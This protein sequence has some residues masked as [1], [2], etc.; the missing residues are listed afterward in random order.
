MMSLVDWRLLLLLLLLLLLH[1]V[2]GVVVVSLAAE[3]EVECRGWG[4]G[5][6]GGRRP[7]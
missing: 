6:W 3:E 4:Q 7:V 5:V 2:V 1:A